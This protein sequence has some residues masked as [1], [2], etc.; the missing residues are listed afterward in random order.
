MLEKIEF[1]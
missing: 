1:T